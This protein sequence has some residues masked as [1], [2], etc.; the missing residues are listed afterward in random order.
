MKKV[1]VAFLVIALVLSFSGTALG[2][3]PKK[4]LTPPELGKVVFIHYEKPDKGPPPGKGKTDKE[5]EPK[6]YTNFKLLGS[7]DLAG[8]RNISSDNPDAWLVNNEAYTNG[9]SYY[10]NPGGPWGVPSGISPAD[11]LNEIISAYEVWD[12]ATTAELFADV[13]QTTSVTPSFDEPDG[14]NIVC[15]WGVA[16][17]KAIAMTIIWFYNWD[18]TT[19]AEGK[20]TLTPDDELLDCDLIFNALQ[21]WSIERN[22][23][24]FHMGN[25]ATH[26]AGHVAGLDDLYADED[27]EMTMYGYGKKGETK[28]CTLEIGDWNG[29]V[30]HYGGMPYNEE[31][32]PYEIPR[33]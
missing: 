6:V 30:A 26:E 18:L 27:S 24:T 9:V 22:K 33:D 12:E 1:L 5:E 23:R 10:F 4:P 17:P 19:D 29:C 7:W 21:K 25:I 14:T 16:P 13:V 15:W 28:K 31:T 8:T 2:A 3:A 11:A 32:W 20:P